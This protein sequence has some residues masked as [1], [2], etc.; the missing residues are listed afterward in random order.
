MLV[1]LTLYPTGGAMA[2]KPD[3]VTEIYDVVG[4]PNAYCGDDF[5]NFY[6]LG[7]NTQT[8]VITD[9]Y[10]K[11]G[12][13]EKTVV[14]FSVTDG[15]VYNSKHPERELPEGPDHARWYFYPDSDIYY[16]AG[17]AFHV[18]VPGYGIIAI[19]AGRIIMIPDWEKDYWEW[20]IIWEKGQNDLFTGDLDAL[21]S[22][23]AVP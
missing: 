18:T 13:L 4:E 8:F 12:D 16:Q 2:V 11:D 14:H 22:Y 10:N 17:L 6:V 7:D 15:R 5:G 9:F 20:E 23:L 1:F 3:T 21:C 19:N